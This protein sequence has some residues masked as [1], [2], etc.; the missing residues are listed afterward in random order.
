M[1]LHGDFLSLIGARIAVG[2]ADVV[3]EDGILEE[4]LRDVLDADRIS[5]HDD[6]LGD[7]AVFRRIVRGGGILLAHSALY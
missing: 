5:G 3:V 7:V 1:R 4:I 2:V 6:G